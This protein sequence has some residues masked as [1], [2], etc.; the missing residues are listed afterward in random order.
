MSI[1]KTGEMLGRTT[2]ILGLAAIVAFSASAASAQVISD[3]RLRGPNGANDEF[4]RIYN[5]TGAPITVA[6]S[7]G[8]GWGGRGF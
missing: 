4:I 3:F 5:N 1:Q 2:R 6:A 8:T 7:S